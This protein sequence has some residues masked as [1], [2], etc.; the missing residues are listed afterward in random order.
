MDIVHEKIDQL[1]KIAQGIPLIMKASEKTKQRPGH[2]MLALIIIT[3]ILILVFL[4]A[5]ILT[6]FLT[7]IYPGYKSILALETTDDPEDDK[8][9]LTY[10]IFFGLL[11]LID[12]FAFFIVAMIPFYFY[13]KLGFFVFLFSPQTKGALKLYH[14]F[15]RGLLKKHQKSIENFIAQIQNE[16][17]AAASDATKQAAQYASDPNNMAKAANFAAQAQSEA[18]KY[19][20]SQSQSTVNEE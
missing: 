9:W 10:W 8:M 3:P 16:A 5:Q 19:S 11:T 1:D 7:V 17:K 14:G 4:G 6:V 18:A 12:E 13:I 20:E 15:L 2:I